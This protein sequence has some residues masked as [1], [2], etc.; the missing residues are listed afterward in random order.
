MASQCPVREETHL[1]L[2]EL[3]ALGDGPLGRAALE[4]RSQYCRER[5][6][7][8]HSTLI[9]VPMM[10]GDRL[11]GV[12]ALGARV[13]RPIGRNELLLLQAFSNRVGEVLASRGDVSDPLAVAMERF[14]ASW[15]ASRPR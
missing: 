2:P 1:E 9:A 5:V 13:S 6:G 10:S 8:S 4:R 3:V 14:R 15:S 11:L 12:L 7:S